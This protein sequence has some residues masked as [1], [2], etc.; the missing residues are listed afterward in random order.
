MAR[1]RQTTEKKILDAVGRLLAVEGFRK[2]G[3]NAV[4]RHAKVDKVLIYRYFGSMP[5]LLRAYAKAGTYWPTIEE[6][7][8]GDP[9][10]LRGKPLHEAVAIL[11]RNFSRAI[12]KRPVTL[13][14]LAWESIERNELAK[15]LEK[16]REDFSKNL[17]RVFIAGRDVTDS[18]L[19]A[20]VSLLTAGINYL[21]VRSR[22]VGRY[23]DVDIRSEEGWHRLESA[24]LTIC[25]RCL[26]TQKAA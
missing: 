13:E 3:I 7:A 19:V 11:L 12:R 23:G 22:K 26:G 20:I 21:A 10:L 18:E 2:F 9:E 15:V 5:D 6:V 1:D 8:G 16:V 24:I 4:A 14:I 25:E 17:S